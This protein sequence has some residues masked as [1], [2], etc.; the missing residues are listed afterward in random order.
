MADAI[1]VE[2]HV[3]PARVIAI[4]A[5]FLAA[6]PVRHNLI[7]TLL[8]R[9]V[10]TG[11]AGRFWT[12][13]D[14]ARVVGITFQ[15]PLDHYAA[16]TP[17]PDTAV[18]AT[19]EQVVADGVVLPGINGEVTASSAFAGRWT[20]CTRSAARP[21][22]A[23]RLYEVDEVLVPRAPGSVRPATEADHT[24][25]AR[26]LDAFAIETREHRG[27]VDAVVARRIASRELWLHD[28]D[29]PV[30]IAG[31]SIPTG[32]AVRV[33]PV[34]TPPDLRG[35]G[36][37]SALVAR[38]SAA[39]RADGLRCLLYAD[40]ANPTSN[41]IYRAIGYAPVAEQVRYEFGAPGA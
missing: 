30:A 21:V 6:E 34:Y 2:A 5:D 4:A 11:S 12:A 14:G 18:V 15:S 9:C 32:G 25:A 39:A 1:R 22:E 10:D 36:Y 24:L 16:M 38:R 37:A 3:D 27:D 17:M 26:W 31:V 13:H 7:A 8:H 33:G 41:A 28:D 40:L 23:M 29:G 19:V 35:H 20:E